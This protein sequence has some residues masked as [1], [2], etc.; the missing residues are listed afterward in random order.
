VAELDV[1]RPFPQDWLIG[2]GRL[3]CQHVILLN[4]KQES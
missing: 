2:W 4:R 1:F 3:L